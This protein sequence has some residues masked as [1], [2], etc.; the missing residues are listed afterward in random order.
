MLDVPDLSLDETYRE[1]YTGNDYEE[2]SA[3]VPH[4]LRPL[5]L[6]NNMAK[7]P[8]Q[9]N[10]PMGLSHMQGCL[11]ASL[12]FSVS[13]ARDGILGH[14]FDKSRLLCDIRS[15]FCWWILNKKIRKTTK[16][17]ESIHEYHFAE[18]KN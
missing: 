12:S 5:Q 4:L 8:G 7:R 6:S 13:W 11:A 10:G 3:K 1:N 14:Q 17:L 2:S 18:R 16:K 15:P 9:G